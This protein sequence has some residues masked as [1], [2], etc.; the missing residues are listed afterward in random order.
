MPSNAPYIPEIIDHPGN[1]LESV[2]IGLVQLAPVLGSR[3]ENLERHAAIASELAH[4]D[5][6]LILFPE[7]SLTGYFL[8]DLVPDVAC[9]LE[10]QHW[11]SL[12][13]AC[14]NSTVIA[15]GVYETAEHIF[16][17]AAFAVNAHEVQIIHEK[18]FLPTYGLFD[19]LR[20]FGRGSRFHPHTFELGSVPHQQWKAGTVICEDMWHLRS[21]SLLADQG[22]DCFLGLSSSPARGIQAK[23]SLGSE[24]SYDAMTRTYAQLTTSYFAYC[25]RV[26]YED[27]VAFWGG[28]R[29]VLPDGS[30]AA[31]PAGRGEEIHV[32]AV[33]HRAV[34]RARIATPL[35]RDE[36]IS[37]LREENVHV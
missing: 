31:E 1:E 12:Q 5:V 30:L 7:L 9:T 4:R 2:R 16:T 22:V 26:G 37:P 19:E 11:T 14:G 36:R 15:G 20:Y 6:H 25:N 18:V 3:D 10:P 35:L 24:Q 17:N 29:L 8:K 33:S 27:G 28:S 23:K 34:R 21:I 32:Y 13:E